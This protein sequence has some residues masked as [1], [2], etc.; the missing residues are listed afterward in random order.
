MTC[1]RIDLTAK[2]GQKQGSVQEA[3]MGKWTEG[4]AQQEGFLILS[5]GLFPLR[6][7]L[8]EGMVALTFENGVDYICTIWSSPGLQ[9]SLE[10][11]EIALN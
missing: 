1:V 10:R 8:Y 6:S 5:G 7:C 4:F 3:E 9:S 2:R 11:N